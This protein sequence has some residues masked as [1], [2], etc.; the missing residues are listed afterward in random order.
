MNRFMCCA[1][2]RRVQICSGQLLWI[3]ADQYVRDRRQSRCAPWNSTPPTPRPPVTCDAH[4]RANAADLCQCAVVVGRVERVGKGG[5]RVRVRPCHAWHACSMRSTHRTHNYHHAHAGVC[6]GI[7]DLT[8][9]NCSSCRHSGTAS[10]ARAADA[11]ANA[12][13]S[14]IVAPRKGGKHLHRACALVDWPYTNRE[15]PWG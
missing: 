9:S 4:A 12:F 1:S 3:H 15:R 6:A 5:M 7:T 2:N 10:R 11:T 8:C 14:A 13:P